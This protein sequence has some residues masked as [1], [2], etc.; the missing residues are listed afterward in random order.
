MDAQTQVSRV[1]FA[2][3]HMVV[4]KMAA[5][6]RVFVPYRACGFVANHVPLVVQVRGS[7]NFPI[8][9]VGRAFHIYNVSITSKGPNLLLNESR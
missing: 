7:E 9:S 2:F 6:S 5:G 1:L 8:T 4:H 3:V